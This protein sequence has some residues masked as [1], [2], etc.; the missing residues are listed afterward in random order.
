[1]LGGGE[2]TGRRKERDDQERGEICE[3]MHFADLQP[4]CLNDPGSIFV[5]Q[6]LLCAVLLG[7]FG[8]P[9]SENIG[10]HEVSFFFR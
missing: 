9:I 2:E 10:D 5:T 6:I 3:M 1:M 8:R 7:E 4:E